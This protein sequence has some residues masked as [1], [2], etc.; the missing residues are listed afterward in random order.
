[1]KRS[2]GQD[3]GARYQKLGVAACAID[4]PDVSAEGE[5]DLS[6]AEGGALQEYWPGPGGKSQ[7]GREKHEE[8][9]CQK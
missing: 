3:S 4:N 5:S 7:C 1:M 2:D 8:K 6:L 9:N